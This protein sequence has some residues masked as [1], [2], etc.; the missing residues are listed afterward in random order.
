[1]RKSEAFLCYLL[2]HVSNLFKGLKASKAKEEERRRRRHL[3]R[4]LA[5]IRITEGHKAKGDN[6]GHLQRAISQILHL[7]LLLVIVPARASPV[8]FEA[9]ARPEGTMKRSLMYALKDVSRG[10]CSKIDTR[11]KRSLSI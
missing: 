4:G 6:R 8:A 2:D 9:L 10:A 1:M 7:P 5:A 3:Q 11:F